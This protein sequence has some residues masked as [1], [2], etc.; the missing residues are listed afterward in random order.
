VRESIF[1]ATLGENKLKA[2]KP[3][4]MIFKVSANEDEKKFI[5]VLRKF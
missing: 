2:L 4:E 3:F 5:P 1:D